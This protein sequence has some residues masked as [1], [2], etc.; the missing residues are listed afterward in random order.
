MSLSICTIPD[1]VDISTFSMHAPDAFQILDVDSG[2]KKIQS[3]TACSS[4]HLGVQCT[5]DLGIKHH[6]GAT[7][8]VDA[9]TESLICQKHLDV[10][11]A[12]KEL[13]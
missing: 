11:N 1:T 12:E 10:S 13:H 9:T 7:R 2:T 5:G 6:H 8:K 3:T 4:S